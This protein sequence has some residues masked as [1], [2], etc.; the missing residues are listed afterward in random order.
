MSL[1]S[2]VSPFASAVFKVCSAYDIVCGS[3]GG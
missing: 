1:F 2:T 3:R